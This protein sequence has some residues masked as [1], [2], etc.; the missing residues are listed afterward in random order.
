MARAV[1]C[2][3]WEKVPFQQPGRKSGIF[4]SSC[5]FRGQKFRMQITCGTRPGQGCFG[6]ILEPVVTQRIP[7]TDFD[8]PSIKFYVSPQTTESGTVWVIYLPSEY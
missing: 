7:Y 1:R 6:Y 2:T 4:S 8:L 3:P 5:D